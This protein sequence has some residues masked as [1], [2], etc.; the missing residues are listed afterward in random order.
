MFVLEEFRAGQ[1][2][3]PYSCRDELPDCCSY[4]V[5]LIYGESSCCFCDSPYFYY[6]AYNWPDKLTHTV[7]PCMP[8]LT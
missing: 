8:A 3:L 5:Y 2:G 6:C 1:Y 4:C 7:P